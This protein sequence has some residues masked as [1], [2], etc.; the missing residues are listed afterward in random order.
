MRPHHPNPEQSGLAGLVAAVL[1]L[2][3]LAWLALGS[4]A[5]LP[6]PKPNPKIGRAHV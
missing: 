6:I 4:S 2:A 3:M 5:A 1:A